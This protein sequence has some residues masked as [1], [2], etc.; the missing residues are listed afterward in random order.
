LS[1]AL[2]KQVTELLNEEKWTRATLNSYS[3]GNFSELDEIVATTKEQS[4]EDEV[5]AVCEEHLKHTRNSIVG[6]YISG[7]ISLSKQLVDD[8]NL[9]VLINIFMDNHKWNIVEYLCSRI[10]EYGEN[11]FALKTLAD[12]YE[13]KNE[14]EKKYE[15]WERY[16]KV[17]YE[18]AEIVKLL[19]DKKEEDGELEAAVEFWKK[20][21]HRFINKKMFSNVREVW[22]KIIEYAPE[23][24]EFF[25]SVERKIVK[26]L[27][28]DRAAQLLA[29]L[30]P[31]YKEKEDWDTAIELLKRILSYEPKNSEARKEI[32]ECFRQKHKDHSQLNEYLR[33]SNLN[34]SWRNVHDAIADFEKHISFDM[35]NY[36]YHSSWKIGQ[37]KD[38]QNDI[39][40]IDFASKPGHKM[41]LKMA[42]SALKVLIP[43]HIWVQI[44]T[45][46]KEELKREVKEDPVWALKTVIRSF[47]NAADMKMIKDQLVPAVLSPAEWSKWSTEARK[48]LKTDPI[49]GNVPEK[50]DRYTVRDKP[51]SFEEKTFNKFKA[52]K[53]FFDR[54]QTLRDFLEH[55]EPDSDYFAEMFSYFT[56]FLKSSGSV[57]EL[58]LSS[59][60]VVQQLA[61]VYPYLN[62]GLESTFADLI[63]EV[64]DIEE[65]FSKI[66]DPEL[67]K[68]FLVQ[69]H[70]NYPDW[71]SVYARLFLT[72]QSKFIVDELVR[73]K[74]WDTLKSLTAQLL[75]HY[76]EY[77]EAFVW[78]ARN[79]LDEPWFARMEIIREKLLIGMIH[80]L[81]IT[82]REINNKRDVSFNRKINKQVQ[83]FLF[84]EK[85]LLNHILET[86]EESITRLYTLVDDVKELNPS[87]RISLKQQI[88]SNFPHYE[89]LGD[90]EKEKVSMGLLST[91]TSYQGKQD[92]LRDII[93]NQI[94]HNST[95]IGVAM[96]KGDL[97]E[98]AEYKAA[99]E[100][101]ELLKS[102]AA[103]IQEELQKAQIFD[104]SKISTEEISFGTK[105][106]LKNLIDN[107][108]EE[109]TIL[110][111]W[112]SNPT[113]NIISYR[114]P[115]GSELMNHKTGDRLSFT[116]SDQNFKYEVEKIEKAE[117][118]E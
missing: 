81:D 95:E 47:D 74:K 49:F 117:L 80:L 103:K 106:K 87:I 41:S 10:L 1:E 72:Y 18:E 11:K 65:L 99:L 55:A 22:E 9:I 100:R 30:I 25:F 51:I 20:A 2:I 73:D 27:S 93:E 12:V 60:M 43:D 69:L 112:E 62:P 3:I 111:P 83:D 97:R 107:S 85:N 67:K 53:S 39:I 66:D 8:S 78:L 109:Y 17:D 15:I 50:L 58:V 6:L 28:G 35:G 110:G 32:V 102:T 118:S 61:S 14:Q 79:L 105:V 84:K 92:E 82:F 57:N 23:D 31:H 46:P 75:S 42:V 77:R 98:N 48:I 86:G 113:K 19:A 68:T 21:L 88:K 44:H 59:F 89:F 90:R 37:I 4:A 52:Q 24:V 38:I 40:V 45:K 94:P 114:S 116:I 70:Q 7:I 54:V 34:Q 76:K 29:F 13:N 16:I 71:A 104:E 63:Q 56:G 5:L 33:I 108:E 96:E 91:R 101:Q 115:L 36:V 26:V 64:E